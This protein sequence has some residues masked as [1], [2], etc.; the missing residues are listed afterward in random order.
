MVA[1][2][3]FYDEEAWLVGTAVVIVALVGHI[4]FTPY[5]DSVTDAVEFLT[6]AAQLLILSAAPVFKVINDPGDPVKG[7]Q[8]ASLKNFLETGSVFVICATCVFGLAAAVRVHLTVK[9]TPNYSTELLQKLKR[10]P[11][12]TTR[13]LD[14]KTVE[15]PEYQDRLKQIDEVQSSMC[16]AKRKALQALLDAFSTDERRELESLDSMFISDYKERVLRERIAESR[17]T[18]ASLR[19]ELDG[20]HE[21]HKIAQQLG[22]L[23][24]DD[25]ADHASDRLETMQRKQDHLEQVQESHYVLRN[26]LAEIKNAFCELEQDVGEEAAKAF[27]DTLDKMPLSHLRHLDTRDIHH[28]GKGHK[29]EHPFN[30]L[31]RRLSGLPAASVSHTPFFG[32]VVAMDI[33]TLFACRVNRSLW[34]S[35]MR[36]SLCKRCRLR[37]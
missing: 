30:H 37:P 13:T 31:H 9:G 3:L 7:A 33:R 22:E 20:L 29:A 25:D 18:T 28:D 14:F 17:Q 5:E 34:K 16:G 6:L 15:S 1:F 36:S 11:S 8:A 19:R 21:I 24:A 27:K 26:V 23:A 32:G 2:F 4:Y 12:D 35:Q 10:P